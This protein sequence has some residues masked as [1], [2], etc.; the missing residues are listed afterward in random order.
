MR[1]GSALCA[2]VGSL[3]SV[4]GCAAASTAGSLH[5]QGLDVAPPLFLRIM[6]FIASASVSQGGSLWLA[7]AVGPEASLCRL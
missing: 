5:L 1:C 2:S 7:V 4:R 6:S 3:T